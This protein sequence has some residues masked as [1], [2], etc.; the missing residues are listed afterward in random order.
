MSG[1]WEMDTKEGPARKPRRLRRASSCAECTLSKLPTHHQQCAMARGRRPARMDSRP[2][3]R[4]APRP[5]RAAQLRLA[6]Q[7]RVGHCRP[8]N[9]LG[10]RD[11]LVATPAAARAGGARGRGTPL[12]RLTYTTH[13]QPRYGPSPAEGNGRARFPPRWERPWPRGP[14]DGRVPRL[15]CGRAMKPLHGPSTSKRRCAAA[16]PPRAALPALTQRLRADV[17]RHTGA[18]SICCRLLHQH[19]RCVSTPGR[20]G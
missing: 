12:P 20:L 3:P 11:P 8:H 5:R 2:P 7:R 14:P 18:P 10:N 4:R 19:R 6:T 1:I 9:R 13:V 17:K 15:P 16:P